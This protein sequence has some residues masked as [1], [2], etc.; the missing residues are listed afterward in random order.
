MEISRMSFKQWPA[1]GVRALYHMADTNDSSGNSLT[2]TNNGSVT[3]GN[4]KFDNCAILGSANSSTYLSRTDGM[5]TDLSGDC[6][7][8]VWFYLQANPASTEQCRIIDWRST[9]GTAVWVVVDYYNNNGTYQITWFPNTETPLSFNC[10][11]NLNT[12]YKMD[13]SFHG[14]AVFL[15]LN[16]SLIKTDTRGTYTQAVNKT[17]IGAENS[18]TAGFFFFGN[19]DEVIFFNIHRTDQEIKRKYLYQRGML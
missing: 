2:L 8:S 4:G 7:F 15:Y 9:T 1:V 6:G 18:A 12:W 14:T 10:T 3:F 17:V 19:I 5:G 11:L 13:V 16:G